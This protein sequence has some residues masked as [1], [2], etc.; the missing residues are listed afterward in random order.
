MPLFPAQPFPPRYNALSIR[1]Q[2]LVFALLLFVA[3]WCQAPA[4][5]TLRGYPPRLSTAEAHAA[6]PAGNAG[7]VHYTTRHGLPTPEIW[8]IRQLQNH[9][10]VVQTVGGFCVFDGIR[11]QPLHCEAQKALPLKHFGSYTAMPVGDSLQWFRNYHHAYLLDIRQ[12]AFIDPAREPAA[13]KSAA[14]LLKGQPQGSPAEEALLRKGQHILD[15][16][17]RGQKAP[18]ATTVCIDHEDF[19]WIGTL[20][21]GIYCLHPPTPCVKLV[22]MPNIKVLAQADDTRLVIGRTD[23][24]LLFDTRSGE[25]VSILVRN[26]GVCHDAHRDTKGRVWVSTDNGLYR[27]DGEGIRHYD[28][29]NSKG[30]LHSKMRFARGPLPDGRM[31]VCNL[32]HW[33]GLLDEKTG[34]F[35]ALNSRY[36]ELER[37]RLYTDAC[38]LPPAGTLYGILSQ[39]GIVTLNALGPTHGTPA[40]HLETDKFNCVYTDSQ[41]R[42]WMGTQNGLLLLQGSGFRRFTL[43]D[44]LRN[45]CINSLT[46][47]R[48]GQLWIGTAFGVEKLVITPSD[49]VFVPYDAMAGMPETL[50]LERAAVAMPDGTVWMASPEGLTC[51]SPTAFATQSAHKAFRADILQWSNSSGAFSVADSIIC[52]DYNHNDLHV[53]FAT[54]WYGLNHRVRYRYRLREL[55]D[56]WVIVHPVSGP[57]A[58][59]FQALPPGTYTLQMQAAFEAGTWGDTSERSIVVRPPFWLSS[60]AKGIY[61]TLLLFLSLWGILLY[62]RR[63]KKELAR[64]NEKKIEQLFEL[65]D[66]AR[67]QFAQNIHINAEKLSINEEETFFMK[68]LLEAIERNMDNADYTI[69]QLAADMAMGRSNLYRK[70]Q[71][72]LG[73]TPNDFLRSVRLK[74]AATLLSETSLQ[75]GEIARAVGFSSPRYFSQY[76]KKMFGVTPSA[77]G[78]RRESTDNAGEAQ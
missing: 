9:R 63:L 48:L 46:E 44:G 76:F 5:G 75:V 42:T 78:Q 64:E 3:S 11:F 49:T 74:R 52:M 56:Q 4:S 7:I 33:I 40:T 35:T 57:V 22:N 71:A 50:M 43:R 65:R 21:D 26:C 72:M 60:W 25:V 67:Q 66:K 10:I 13:R 69:D 17:F 12:M 18:Q 61:A 59:D 51:F 68:K 31:L 32:Q 62:R 45:Q 36:P 38:P 77:Y 54:P 53:Q 47:D 16:L 28:T 41:K 15:S 14:T 19:I 1:L 73:I 34:E 58:I 27:Y 2:R 29:S 6:L 8:Q 37:H 24:I 39:N 23:D 55:N 20:T 70:T 30:F